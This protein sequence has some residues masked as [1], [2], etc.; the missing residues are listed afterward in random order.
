[1]CPMEAFTTNP[2]S[3]YFWIVLTLV[4]DS[5]TTSERDLAKGLLSASGNADEALPG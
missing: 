5:T 3:R 1:M 4:G 2:E